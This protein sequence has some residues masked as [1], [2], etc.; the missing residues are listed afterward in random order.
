[1]GVLTESMSRLRDEIQ[2]LRRSRQTFRAEL[3]RSTE[4]AQAEVAALRRGIANDL[5]GARRAWSGDV[6]DVRP[7]QQVVRRS[8]EQ[9]LSAAYLAGGR[10]RKRKRH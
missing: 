3:A 9:G 8:L 5:A 6:S 7:Q 4:S 1:M 10:E 2:Q